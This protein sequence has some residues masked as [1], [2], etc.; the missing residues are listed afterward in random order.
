MVWCIPWIDTRNIRNFMTS[1][2]KYR[3]RLHKSY[4]NRAAHLV[5]GSA[6]GFRVSAL[7]GCS[8]CCFSGVSCRAS[9]QIFHFMAILSMQIRCGDPDTLM[10]QRQK[11]CGNA[12]VQAWHWWELLSWSPSWLYPILIWLF[13]L[14]LMQSITLLLSTTTW[15]EVV[16][17]RG[18]VSPPT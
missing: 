2:K 15:E 9:S 11:W 16:P 13:P 3:F 6:S 12:E 8:R 17:R 10:A 4:L 5:C 14:F 1:L 7:L 18:L